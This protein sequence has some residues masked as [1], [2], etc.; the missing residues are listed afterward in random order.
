MP[1]SSLTD[2]VN[3]LFSA[4]SQL[5][6]YLSTISTIHMGPLVI[7]LFIGFLLAILVRW[8]FTK[9]GT[10]LSNRYEF[11][12]IFPMILLT[13]A[14]IIA[15]VKSSLALALGLVGALSIVRFRTPIKEPEE[16]AYLF[17]II[18]LGVALGAGQTLP[19]VGAC[20]VIL[21]CVTLA[22]GGSKRKRETGL[23]LSLDWKMRPETGEQDNS[24]WLQE[25]EKIIMQHV[26]SCDLRRFDDREGNVEALYYVDV[27]DTQALSIITTKLRKMYKGIGISF[28]DQKNVSG[29]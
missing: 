21:F 17:L 3:N 15:I 5:N 22:K 4:S 14:L 19:A 12:S 24:Q 29:F 8:H 23:Y 13:I 1:D 2:K 20:F 27:Q 10:T 25:F 11:A 9:Y 6:E 26:K 18:G 16:L 7:N 28:L